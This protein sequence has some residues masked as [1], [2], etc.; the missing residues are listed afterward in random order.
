MGI[1]GWREIFINQKENI[2]EE[3]ISEIVIKRNNARKDKNWKLADE[4]RSQ[5]ESLGFIL[6]DNKDSTTWE[7]IDQ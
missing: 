2:N 5:A 3:M 7:P 1:K 4:L 6:I